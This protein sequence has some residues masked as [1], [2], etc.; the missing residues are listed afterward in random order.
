MENFAAL[1][2]EEGLLIVVQ[3]GRNW[4]PTYSVE[5]TVAKGKNANLVILDEN[6]LNDISNTQKIFGV[7]LKGKYYDRKS[8]ERMKLSVQNSYK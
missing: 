8:L 5:G 2:E 1:G 6:P 7:V 4:F 3:D